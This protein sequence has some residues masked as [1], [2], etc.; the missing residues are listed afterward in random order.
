MNYLCLVLIPMLTACAG[1]KDPSAAEPS[2][3]MLRASSYYCCKSP[4]A[5]LEEEP[6]AAFC[7]SAGGRLPDNMTFKGIFVCGSPEDASAYANWRRG[8]GMATVIRE[9]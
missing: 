9:R 8:N 2:A 1:A 5:T 7:E 4:A 6:K 3:S